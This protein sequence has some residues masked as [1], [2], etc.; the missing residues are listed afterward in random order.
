MCYEVD[1][2]GDFIDHGMTAG[3][4]CKT[5][6]ELSNL[7]KRHLETLFIIALKNYIAT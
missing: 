4:P 1:K 3:T 5:L 6:S 7:E 2:S